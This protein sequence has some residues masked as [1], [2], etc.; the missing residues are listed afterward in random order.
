MPSRLMQFLCPPIKRDIQ[1]YYDRFYNLSL[2]NFKVE[3]VSF[4]QADNEQFISHDCGQPH[5]VCQAAIQVT[6]VK[7]A[8]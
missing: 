4:R 3:D 1:A 5:L 8:Y 7:Y 2:N 6:L